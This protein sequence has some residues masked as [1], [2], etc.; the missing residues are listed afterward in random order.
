MHCGD[1]FFVLLEL[2]RFFRVWFFVGGFGSEIALLMVFG[3]LLTRF[4]IEIVWLMVFG[5][6][7]ALL[8]VFGSLLVGLVLRLLC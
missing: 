5:S 7:I 8:M 2:T 6:E 4:W 3:S 1:W